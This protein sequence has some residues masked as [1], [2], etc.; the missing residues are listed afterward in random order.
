MNTNSQTLLTI[1]ARREV[2][3]N[4]ITVQF[5]YSSIQ[6]QFSY[7]VIIHKYAYAEFTS[8]DASLELHVMNQKDQV[9]DHKGLC[10]YA[11]LELASQE[12]FVGIFVLRDHQGRRFSADAGREVRIRR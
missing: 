11:V 4:T 1:K 5:S 12:D 6:I 10:E 9:L 8:W 2:M 3:N 7:F